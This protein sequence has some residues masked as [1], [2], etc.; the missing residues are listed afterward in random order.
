MKEQ[1]FGEYLH[2]FRGHNDTLAQ[3]SFHSIGVNFSHISYIHDP[4]FCG[5]MILHELIVC[6]VMKKASAKQTIQHLGDSQ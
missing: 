3:Y 5:K 1:T 2:R 4:N 6:E